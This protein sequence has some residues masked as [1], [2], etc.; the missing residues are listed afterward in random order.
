MVVD[1]IAS[2]APILVAAWPHGL[3]VDVLRPETLDFMN[4]S[5]DF[6]WISKGFE[7]FR[8]IKEV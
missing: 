8:V 7:A 4:M 5:E 6:R 3:L 1:G 2:A